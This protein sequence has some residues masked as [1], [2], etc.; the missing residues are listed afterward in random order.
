MPQKQGFRRFTSFHRR[1]K[2]NG[3]QKQEPGAAPGTVEHVGEQR[4]EEIHITL[5]DYNQDHVIERDIETIEEGK[6]YLEKPTNTWI[7][8][9]GLHDIE[10]LKT[11]WNYFELHPLMQE[12]IADTAQ[13]PKV[14]HYDDYS[15]FV[16]RM[17]HYSPLREELHSE[18]VSIVLGENVV[19]SFQ[20]SDKPIFEPIF[21]RLKLRPG[22]IRQSGPDY[23]TYAL[24]D[25][26][27][28]HYFNLLAMFGE[29]IEDIE[30]QLMVDPEDITFQNIHGLRKKVIY[31][32]KTIWPLR[33]VLNSTIRD[34]S[35][36]VEASTKIYL[37]DVY[38]HVVQIIDNMENY[39]DMIRGT[40]DMYTSHMSNKMNEVMKVLTIIA[41]IFIPLTFITGIYGMNF[42]YMPGIEWKWGYPSA[43]LVML[44]VGA[45]MLIYFKIKDWL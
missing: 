11:I 35:A 10:K 25:T 38:D 34:D 21:E 23:L 26:V 5:H 22:R 14:E 36:F 12:D 40:H 15:F 7:N 6:P 33:D 29:R 9:Q 17:L 3:Q 1:S 18:Q 16:V 32:R 31:A 28:D 45:G 19:L 2:D 42:T 44:V 20:E 41:T 39:R 27:V 4:M 8:V 43:L 13:R 30:D 24:I 37:R